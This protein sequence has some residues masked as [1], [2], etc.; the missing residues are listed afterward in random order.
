M[1]NLPKKLS[2]VSENT[3]AFQEILVLRAK[4]AER[5]K[6]IVD[7]DRKKVQKATV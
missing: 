4:R 6:S 3:L 2:I 7:V 1:T 5:R